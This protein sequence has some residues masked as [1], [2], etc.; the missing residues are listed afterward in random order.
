MPPPSQGKRR[1]RID[2]WA[3]VVAVLI[4]LAIAFISLSD[5]FTYL[6]IGNNGCLIVHNGWHFHFQC[7][8]GPG[9]RIPH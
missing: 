1:R 3:V 4:A 6:H 8:S 2:A 7:G 9:S 5:A